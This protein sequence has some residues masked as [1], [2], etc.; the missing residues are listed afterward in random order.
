MQQKSARS[1]YARQI[2]YLQE[3]C[4]P[5]LA[6]SMVHQ[7][8]LAQSVTLI[9]CHVC[10]SNCCRLS[11]LEANP[12]LLARRFRSTGKATFP[13]HRNTSHETYDYSQIGNYFPK[14]RHGWKTIRL[15][16]CVPLYLFNAFAV[17]LGRCI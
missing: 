15:A 10:P 17:R 12:L 6:W 11:R 16:F 13:L 8:N 4:T 5:P 9:R 2:L 3:I 1:A 14:D 7:H